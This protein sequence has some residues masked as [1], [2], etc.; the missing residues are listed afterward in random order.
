MRVF[1]SFP[2][3]LVHFRSSWSGFITSFAHSLWRVSL[4]FSLSPL[5]PGSRETF[6][7]ID[8]GFFCSTFLPTMTL[9]GTYSCFYSWGR[10]GDLPLCVRGSAFGRCVREWRKG[11][12]RESRASRGWCRCL[13]LY[14]RGGNLLGESPS[15]LASS[16]LLLWSRGR[17]CSSRSSQDIAASHLP[18]SP[19]ASVGLSVTSA[20]PPRQYPFSPSSGTAGEVLPARRKV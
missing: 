16:L 5:S 12:R 20:L 6:L 1:F 2:H 19:H 10:S 13:T 9:S 11:R 8:F 7:S 18:S 15:S 17:G 3:R 4:L 14:R